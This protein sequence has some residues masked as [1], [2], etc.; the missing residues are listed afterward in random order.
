MDDSLAPNNIDIRGMAPYLQVY[1]MPTSIS[2]YRD[3]LGF[4][5]VM[6]SQPEQGDDCDWV[7]LRLNDAELMLNTIYEKPHRP[8][9][10][11]SVRQIGHSDV[12]LYFGCPDVDAL[13]KLLCAKGLNI[14][15]PGITGYGFKAIHFSDPDGYGLC[16]HWPAK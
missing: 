1:D 2:F 13:Y 3:K 11:D 5:I 6:Q 8:P 16:F 9:V 4:E 15:E 7:L 12:A 10:A 14:K